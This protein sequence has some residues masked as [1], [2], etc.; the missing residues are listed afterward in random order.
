MNDKSISRHDSFSKSRYQGI[1]ISIL[2]SRFRMLSKAIDFRCPKFIQNIFKCC[3]ILHNFLLI[4]DGLDERYNNQ[5]FW[6]SVNVNEEIN[7]E[8]NDMVLLEDNDTINLTMTTT[9]INYDNALPGYHFNCGEIHFEDKINIMITN[10]KKFHM[11][12]L[13]W[14]KSFNKTKKNNTVL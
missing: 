10:N 4:H 6:E 8:S 1:K 7:Q 5:S 2:K 12:L 3:C 9:Q 13:E 14:P 11:G